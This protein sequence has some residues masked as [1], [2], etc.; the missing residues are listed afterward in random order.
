[1]TPAGWRSEKTR[2]LFQQ[3]MRDY[4]HP[5]IGLRGVATIT[6]LDILSV[7]KPLWD[8]WHV[9][10]GMRAQTW[11]YRILNSM[12]GELGGLGGEARN[13]AEW[14]RFKDKLGSPY[15]IRSAKHHPAMPWKDVPAFSDAES[16]ESGCA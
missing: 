3:A 4:V 14:D 9:M 13:P 16:F 11:L 7:L 2:I 6:G 1:M 8:A 10:S 5:A 12:G 15:K